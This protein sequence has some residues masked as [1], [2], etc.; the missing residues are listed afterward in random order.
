M[1]KNHVPADDGLVTDGFLKLGR[2]LAALES[3]PVTPGGAGSGLFVADNGDGTATLTLAAGSPAS[4]TD[5]GD[6]TATLT[7]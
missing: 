7:T 6:G 4:L 2:R 5:N 3:R 1:A